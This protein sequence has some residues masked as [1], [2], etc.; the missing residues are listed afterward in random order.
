MTHLKNVVTFQTS[1]H[2]K[3]AFYTYFH[4]KVTKIP[5]GLCYKTFV[6]N[7]LERLSLTGVLSQL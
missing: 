6:Q 4:E 2:L 7:K 1:V 5:T 3:G